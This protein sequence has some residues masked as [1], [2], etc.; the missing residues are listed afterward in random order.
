MQHNDAFKRAWELANSK[1]HRKLLWYGFIPAVF[2]TTLTSVVY[3]FRGYQY[4]VEL[5]QGDSIQGFIFGFISSLS[6]FIFTHPALGTLLI[7][8]GVVYGLGYWLIPVYLQGGLMKL[9]DLIVE[10]KEPR[11]RMGFVYGGQY[12]FKLFELKALFSPFRLTWIFLLYW[13]TRTFQP[14]LMGFIFPII[15]VWFVIAVIMNFL[16]IFCEYFIVLENKGVFASVPASIQMVFLHLEQ[17]LYLVLL[18]FLI[19]LRVIFNIIITFGLP[20]LMVFIMGLFAGSVVDWL[21]MPLIIGGGIVSLLI[22]A[23]INGIFTVFLTAAWVLMFKQY[24]LEDQKSAES[25]A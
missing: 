20:L 22:L 15:A 21:A 23:Y 2:T 4:W 11:F 18:M 14:E 24:T 12:F 7:L 19:G 1:K 5:V 3:S 9:L 17:V 6:S 25:L 13:F 10:G 16:F 8:L